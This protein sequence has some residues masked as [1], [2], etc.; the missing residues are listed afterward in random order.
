ML[1]ALPLV[2]LATACIDI[3]VP[4]PYPALFVEVSGGGVGPCADQ[5]WGELTD[6]GAAVHVSAFGDDTAD[7]TSTHPV[8]SPGVGLELTR[9]LGSDV[10]FIGPGTFPAQLSLESDDGG[11]NN[12][13]GLQVLGC[14]VDETSMV[15]LDAEEPVIKVS[16]TQEAVLMDF[17]VVGGKRALTF[18]QGATATATRLHIVGYTHGGVLIDGSSSD[19]H[20]DHVDVDDPGSASEGL[21]GIGVSGGAFTMVG[22]GVSRAD[23]IGILADFALLTLD[24]VRIAQTQPFDA[25]TGHGV[26]AQELSIVDIR[27]STI[28]SNAGVGIYSLRSVTTVIFDA[29]VSNT[30]PSDETADPLLDG[31][32]I[33]VTRGDSLVD[34]ASFQVAVE[35]TQVTGSGR[36][37]VVFSG[38]TI[39]S[40]QGNDTTGNVYSGPDGSSIFV[41]ED[42]VPPASGDVWVDL[43]TSDPLP[44]C[45]AEVASGG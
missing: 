31:D 24:G 3:Y 6:P 37:G 30:N 36:A 11:G 42:A 9:S 41:Q 18:W 22:G 19:V 10:L 28:L 33:V 5:S 45:G 29:L 2:L 44:M 27:A 7:G 40:I 26:H 8:L 38:V 43:T 25:C 21:Y 23:N 15:E 1:R 4:N 32:G 14:G 16:G 39:T 20:F 12:D 17:A 34:P 13:D 35:D